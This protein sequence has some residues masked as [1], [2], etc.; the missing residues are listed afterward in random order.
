M[1]WNESPG[2]GTPTDPEGVTDSSSS[3]VSCPYSPSNDECG[4]TQS[5]LAVSARTDVVTQAKAVHSTFYTDGEW[6]PVFGCTD[7]DDN[8]VGDGLG[9]CTGTS[10]STPQ[11][12]AILQLM[13][14]T[15]PLLP[16]GDYDPNNLTGLIN[17]LNATATSSTGSSEHNPYYGYGMPNARK[18]L[19]TLLGKSNG[20]Q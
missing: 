12:A 20:I 19:E 5:F 1:F 11:T 3:T 13:R 15:L 9:N 4:S 18:A 7:S 14:S 16:N 10:M 17:V 8:N 6:N 2:P